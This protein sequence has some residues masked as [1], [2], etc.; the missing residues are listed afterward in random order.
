MGLAIGFL[1]D[2][3]ALFDKCCAGYAHQSDHVFPALDPLIDAR[4]QMPDL[5]D[6]G[7]MLSGDLSHQPGPRGLGLGKRF[8]G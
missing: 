8:A 5:V 6:L 2:C 7:L 3:S 4:N 1:D